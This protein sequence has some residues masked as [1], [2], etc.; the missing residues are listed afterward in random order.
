MKNFKIKCLNPRIGFTRGKIYSVINGTFADDDG[1]PRPIAGKV[2]SGDFEL[3]EGSKMFTKDDIQVN[4]FVF[5]TNGDYGRVAEF[6]GER[7]LAYEKPKN[8]H[9]DFRWLSIDE[10][11]KVCRPAASYQLRYEISD[12]DYGTVVFD[13]EKGIGCEPPVKEIS[14][15]EAAKLLTEKFGQNVRIRVGE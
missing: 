4:D 7:V 8:N 11:E 2:G 13:R 9:D 5:F 10:I 14:V 6:C 1:D 15:D 3:V 12:G